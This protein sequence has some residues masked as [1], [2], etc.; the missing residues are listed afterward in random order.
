MKQCFMATIWLLLIC[1]ICS[2]ANTP[3]TNQMLVEQQRYENFR[4]SP[5]GT[6]L[7][8]AYKLHD[9]QTVIVKQINNGQASTIPLPANLSLLWAHWNNTGDLLYLF[10]QD[11]QGELLVY[12]WDQARQAL[13]MPL[14]KKWLQS[15]NLGTKHNF[16]AFT[17]QRF[18]DEETNKLVDFNPNDGS[19]H[20]VQNRKSYLPA[21]WKGHPAEF[22]LTS[23]GGKNRWVL[24]NTIAFNLTGMDNLMGTNLISASPDLRRA[25]FLSS[26]DRD[27]LA[28]VSIDL[29]TGAVS[30]IASRDADIRQVLLHPVNKSPVGFTWGRERNHFELIDKSY[31]T[32]VNYIRRA[33][34]GEFS[35]IDIAA[36]N[37]FMLIEKYG[38]VS[39]WFRYDRKAKTLTNIPLSTTTID[40]DLHPTESYRFKARDGLELSVFLTP[41]AKGTCASAQCPMIFSLHGGPA[42]RDYST[43]DMERNWLA[44]R[45][46]FVAH[47]NYR[48]SSGYG[49]HFQNLD[50]GNWG[51][52]MQ[53][54]VEDALRFILKKEPK[55][56]AEKVGIK[57]GSFGGRMLLNSLGRGKQFQCGAAI[58]AGSD[59]VQFVESMAIKTNGTTDLYLRAGDPRTPEGRAALIKAS[60]LSRAADISAPILLIN[61]AKDKLNDLINSAEFTDKVSRVLRYHE[62]TGGRCAM[63]QG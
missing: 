55:I 5:T 38:A 26:V 21:Y 59:L 27:K 4:L 25:W 12:S 41:P 46:Y 35:I 43:P 49:K 28:L 32:D 48:G 20:P 18:L 3:I 62:V 7:A 16:F 29:K 40:A 2:A 39:T 30:E 54:D 9:K 63:M 33:M 44:S 37:Q 34:R 23:W 1:S 51:G 8:Y 47:L 57:G 61:G 53:E 6:N 45:G 24:N 56:A 19:L 60:P 58:V 36:S 52:S 13:A 50:I 17:I 22:K 31:Q 42:T 11:S 10:C 15:V 14:D